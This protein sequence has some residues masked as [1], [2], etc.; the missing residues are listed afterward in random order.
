MLVD[1]RSREKLR[2]DGFVRASALDSGHFGVECL[3]M[4]DPRRTERV[5]LAKSVPLGWSRRAAFQP[6]DGKYP[7]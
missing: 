6:V 3:N 7:S 5:I 1:G 4:A 2:E